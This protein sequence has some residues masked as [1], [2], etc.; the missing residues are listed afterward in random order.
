MVVG[1]VYQTTRPSDGLGLLE[2]RVDSDVRPLVAVL[3]GV[4]DGQVALLGLDGL[5]RRDL[6]TLEL[7]QLGPVA[8]S[9]GPVVNDERLARVLLKQLVDRVQLGAAG[10]ALGLRGDVVNGNEGHGGRDGGSGGSGVL[11]HGR[12]YTRLGE[13]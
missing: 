1:L 6:D 3:V 2:L 13:V 7:A 9:L 5:T 8:R 10:I 4:A 12:E 11:S